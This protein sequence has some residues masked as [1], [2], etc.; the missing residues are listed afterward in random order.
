MCN[1]DEAKKL[2][3]L[4]DKLCSDGSQHINVSRSAD[5]DNAEDSFDIEEKTQNSTDCCK[6]NM[7]CNIPTLHKGID[8]EEE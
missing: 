8:D 7:A 1:N 5:T 4:L 3:E 2:A 6:G